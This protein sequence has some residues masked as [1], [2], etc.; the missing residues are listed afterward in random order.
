MIVETD[1]RREKF[2]A[3]QEVVLIVGTY[4]GYSPKDSNNLTVLEKVL[5]YNY[6]RTN[7]VVYKSGSIDHVTVKTDLIDKDIEVGS[8]IYLWGRVYSYYRTDKSSSFSVRP[9]YNNSVINP[10]SAYL[11][12]EINKSC[13]AV[14][15][16][17]IKSN[18]KRFNKHN[19]MLEKLWKEFV[20]ECPH[21]LKSEALKCNLF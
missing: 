1:S 3:G 6:N 15:K 8:K 10:K 11:L 16:S 7:N 19:L 12:N 9:I 4:T 21:Y 20:K 13:R 14:K 2:L 18:W 17:Y 5:V